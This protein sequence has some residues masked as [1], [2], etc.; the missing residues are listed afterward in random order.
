[1]ILVYMTTS[2]RPNIAADSLPLSRCRGFAWYAFADLWPAVAWLGFFL[3]PSFSNWTHLD[4]ASKKQI[5]AK[6]NPL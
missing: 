6:P 4:F 3:G 1:M 2:K 5:T